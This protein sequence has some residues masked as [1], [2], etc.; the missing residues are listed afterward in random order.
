PILWLMPMIVFVVTMGLGMDYD[1]FLTTRIR[2]EVVRGYDDREAIV[3]AVEGTGKIIT[4]C[5]LI[6]SGAFA[7][8]MLSS[9]S[10]LQEFGFA[11][12]FAILLDATLVRI[13][14]V[15][16]IM[17]LLEGWNWWAPG[18]LQRVGRK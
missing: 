16:A 7:S 11:L 8:M 2:E 4:A 17:V 5:G 14:L 13:Y 15:P 12:A 18:R 9:T 1:V 6:M 10:L 3:R